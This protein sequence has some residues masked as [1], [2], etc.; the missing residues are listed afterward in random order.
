[1]AYIIRITCA[2]EARHPVKY[3]TKYGC[4]VHDS[5][6][7]SCPERRI[8]DANGVVHDQAPRDAA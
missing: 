3:S 5:F 2:A 7:A 6:Y 1:M 4:Y 8:I